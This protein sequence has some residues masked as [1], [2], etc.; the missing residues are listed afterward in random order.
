MDKL[1][2]DAS[3]LDL[4]HP[5]HARQWASEV[6]AKRPYRTQFF[7]TIAESLELLGVQ[8]VLELGSGPGFLAQ[9]LRQH[10]PE[11]DLTLLDF[12][13]A[14]HDLARERL[15]PLATGVEFVTK[16]LREADWMVGLPR[17]D[18]VVTMQAVHE[19]RHK[20]RAVPLHRAVRERLEGGGEYLV[21]DHFAGEGGMSDRDLYMTVEEQRAALE[22]AG[23]DQVKLLLQEGSLV[24]HRAA[25]KR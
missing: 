20:R 8:S 6:M 22:A 23:F 24:L 14:M 2:A 10:M 9:H 1:F 18:A 16:S 5:Q 7:E 4:R 17:F 13:P 25:A 11:L 21:C 19:L 3:S 12:S 15:G